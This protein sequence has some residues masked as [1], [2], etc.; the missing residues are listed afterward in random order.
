MRL[1]SLGLRTA[2]TDTQIELMAAPAVGEPK[3]GA[4]FARPPRAAVEVAA[5]LR[6]QAANKIGP[7]AAPLGKEMAVALLLAA[8]ACAPDACSLHRVG[9]TQLAAVNAFYRSEGDRGRARA[10]EAVFILRSGPP[11]GAALSGEAPIIGADRLEL[12]TA[13]PAGEQLLFLRSL[14]IARSR[15]RRGLGSWLASASAQAAGLPCYCFAYAHLTLLY[16]SAGFS[17][18]TGQ[19]A[20]AG[21]AAH[22]DAIQAREARHGRPLVCM[23][24][25][26]KGAVLPLQAADIVPLLPHAPSATAPPPHTAVDPCSAINSLKPSPPPSHDRIIHSHDTHLPA[27][28]PRPPPVSLI[29]LQHS[30]EARRPTAT[31]P[32][33][34]H[35]LLT[36]HLSVDTWTW[37]GRADNPK[38]DALLMAQGPALVLLWSDNQP[39]AD[40][41]KPPTPAA[42]LFWADHLAP[43]EETRRGVQ[44]TGEG[45]ARAQRGAGRVSAACAPGDIDAHASVA[46]EAYTSEETRDGCSLSAEEEIDSFEDGASRQPRRALASG[47]GIEPDLTT[48]ILLDGT[49]QEARAI[50]RKGPARLRALQRLAL[51]PARPSRYVLRRD[52]GWRS[53]FGGGDGAELLCTAECAAELLE[54]VAGDTAGGETLRRLLGEFQ[55]WF[56]ASRRG[57]GTAGAWEP[58]LGAAGQRVGGGKVE[59]AHVPSS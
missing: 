42:R 9:R 43:P 6:R 7:S 32:L 19:E 30:N 38:I 53:R 49:W 36:P 48:F 46:K 27:P 39:A 10:N 50:Y 59:V 51:A 28:G 25:A 1:V 22:F 31:A 24:R 13:G 4:S 57:G 37:S 20:P 52:R 41:T 15:Q 44:Q 54:G 2:S 33:L 16:A 5:L 23:L 40:E 55:R 26:G 56:E 29:L 58:G 11:E 14:C 35:P 45:T 3:L 47:D 21:V 8:L 18:V 12:R 17:A 34:L